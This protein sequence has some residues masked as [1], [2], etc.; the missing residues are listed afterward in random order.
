[1]ANEDLIGVGKAIAPLTEGI[2]KICSKLLNK[3]A[4][5]VGEIFTE[6]IRVKSNPWKLRNLLDSLEKTNKILVDHGL[7]PRPI[8]KKQLYLS[9]DGAS[10]EEDETLQ[11]L[12]AGLLASVIQGLETHPA[13]PTILGQITPSEAKILDALF[14]EGKNSL[15]E[16]PVIPTIKAIPL[17]SF[18]AQESFTEESLMISTENLCRLNLCILEPVKSYVEMFEEGLGTPKVFPSNIPDFKPPTSPFVQRTSLYPEIYQEK[19]QLTNL[20]YAFVKACQP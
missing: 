6:W 5:E 19:I 8:S 15:S 17:H 11:C 14:L 7:E 16:V 1:M 10:L 4:E 20:G 3:P 2:N 9:F 12:W 18:L 13:Y